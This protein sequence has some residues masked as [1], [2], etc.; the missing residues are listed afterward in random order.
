MNPGD[1]VEILRGIYKGAIGELVQYFQP[2]ASSTQMCIVK[3][4][5]FQ[6]AIDPWDLASVEVEESEPNETDT[7]TAGNL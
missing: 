3:Y 4:K 2:N 6:I 5:A 1:K 7:A